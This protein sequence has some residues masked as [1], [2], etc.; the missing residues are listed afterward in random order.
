MTCRTL[1]FAKLKHKQAPTYNP[2]NFKYKTRNVL[3]HKGKSRT[4]SNEG[5]SPQIRDEKGARK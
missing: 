2:E 3:L 4:R 5:I 1:L